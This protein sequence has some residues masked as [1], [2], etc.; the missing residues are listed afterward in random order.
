MPNGDPILR[1]QAMK[2]RPDAL[3]EAG[4][5]S[6]QA[7]GG[8]MRWSNL[9]NPIGDFAWQENRFEHICH[10]MR[11]EGKQNQMSTHLN[12]FICHDW[13]ATCQISLLEKRFIELF[14]HMY[15]CKHLVHV[16]S[17]NFT[18]PRLALSS[19]QAFLI[20]LS[21]ASHA[22]LPLIEGGVAISTGFQV[23]R[24][25]EHQGFVCNMVAV[26]HYCTIIWGFQTSCGIAN[27]SGWISVSG[28]LDDR[29][30][31]MVKLYCCELIQQPMVWLGSAQFHTAGEQAL[32]MSRMA[33]AGGPRTR[34]GQQSCWASWIGWGRQIRPRLKTFS[35]RPP[36]WLQ[37]W[38]LPCSNKEPPAVHWN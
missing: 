38:H 2:S 9:A 37:S 32:R 22:F 8:D 14:K 3:V 31:H 5:F 15:N 26:I 28:G 35:G 7:L 12:S 25:D 33:T 18:L 19:S 13:N 36:V 16:G 1:Q 27:H 20:Q 11:L 30:N 10:V 17:V 23:F 4:Q 24:L 21:Q 6:H 29:V 34:P